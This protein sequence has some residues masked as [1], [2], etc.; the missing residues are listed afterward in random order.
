[1]E[2]IFKMYYTITPTILKVEMALA[3]RAF[4]TYKN[5]TGDTFNETAV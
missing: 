1:M 2:V 4:A 3:L 5:A